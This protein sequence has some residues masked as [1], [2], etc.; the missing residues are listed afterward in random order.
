MLLFALASFGCTPQYFRPIE[1]PKANLRVM[2]QNQIVYAWLHTYRELGCKSPMAMGALGPTSHVRLVE[3]HNPIGMLGSKVTPDTRIVEQII[4]ADR[5]FTILFTQHGPH[6]MDK[7][8]TCSLPITFLPIPDKHYEVV[9]DF[10]WKQCFITVEELKQAN[11]G[12]TE[13]V[14]V[15]NVT[16][17]EAACGPFRF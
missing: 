15:S 5:P 10:D 2:T 6:T 4:P 16:K 13:R 8:R 3:H 17:E 11:D 9:Y 1:G 7:V 12:K 14:K